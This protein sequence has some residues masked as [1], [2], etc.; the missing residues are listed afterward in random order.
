MALSVSQT[1]ARIV[2]CP[3]PL[4]SSTP[5]GE[6]SPGVAEVRGGAISCREVVNSPDQLARLSGRQLEQLCAQANPR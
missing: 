1:L 4:L 2:L 3:G 6:Q 5:V